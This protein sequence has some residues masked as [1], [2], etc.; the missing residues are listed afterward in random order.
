[1]PAGVS[2]Y[3]SSNV[4]AEDVSLVGRWAAAHALPQPYNS[5][6][7]K[8]V[9]AAT[10]AVTFTL[11]LA[12][13]VAVPPPGATT[14][15]GDDPALALTGRD[16]AF[17]GATIRVQPGDYRPLMGRVVDSLE[18][19]RAAALNPTQAAMLSRYAESFREGSQTAHIEGSKL[20]VK[21]SGCGCGGG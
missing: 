8:A 16:H 5:R 4:T 12:A 17:E 9:D 15:P 10:G 19:A 3:Y 7:F 21:V 14:R 18:A 6:L 13:A 20:W 11:R 1:V 2:T